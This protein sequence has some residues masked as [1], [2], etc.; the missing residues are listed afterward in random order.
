MAPPARLALKRD[1]RR[2]R[3]R[4][5]PGRKSRAQAERTRERI[6]EAA[7]L[8]VRRVGLRHG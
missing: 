5:E 1:A 8:L 4:D 2:E 3:P 7:F 6:V